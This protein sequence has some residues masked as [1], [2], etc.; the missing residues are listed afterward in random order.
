MYAPVEVN[1]D[2]VEDVANAFYAATPAQWEEG[3]SR[4]IETSQLGKQM[5]G[6]EKKRVLEK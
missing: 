2:L 5:A 6:E 3:F 4:P 1:R